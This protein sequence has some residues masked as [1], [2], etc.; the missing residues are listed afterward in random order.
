VTPAEKTAHLLQEKPRAT[1]LQWLRG[2]ILPKT[3]MLSVPVYLEPIW[4]LPLQDTPTQ[5]YVQVTNL[6]RTRLFQTAV[7]LPD[8]TALQANG[9]HVT[10]DGYAANLAAHVQDALAGIAGVAADPNTEKQ[11]KID[12]LWASNGGGWVASEGIKTE[13]AE[14]WLRR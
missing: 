11:A 12:A 10:P 13:K 5:A 14:K 2:E 8:G 3:D 6:R 9:R 1:I 7:E 4:A